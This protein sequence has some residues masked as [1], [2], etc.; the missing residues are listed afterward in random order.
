M[1]RHYGH[2]A[3]YWE[4]PEDPGHVECWVCAAP[5]ERSRT[6]WKHH[7]ETVRV[8]RP[9]PGDAK[10]YQSARELVT[11]AL[12]NLP[13]DADVGEQAN[14]VVDIL[15]WRGGLRTRLPWRRPD[16]RPSRAA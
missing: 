6:G 5:I 9:L 12:C 3:R 8:G 7:D 16:G 2:P 13:Q 15:Y 10:A 11:A 14:A 4:D 1:A